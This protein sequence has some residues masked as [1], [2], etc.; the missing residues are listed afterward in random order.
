MIIRTRIILVHAVA[1]AFAASAV[2][3]QSS[4]ATVREYDRIFP[5]YPF[6]DPNPIPVVGRIYPYFRFDG[7][8]SRSVQHSWKVVELENDYIRV[9]ILPEIGGKIW[10]AVDKRTGRSFIYFNQTVKFRDIAMRGP[11]TSGGI[12]ANY[13]IIGHTPNVATPVDYVARTNADGSVSCIIGALD[14]LTRTPWRLE[15]RLGRN[16]AAFSTTSF[17]YNASPVEQPYYSWMNAGIKVSGNLQFIYPGTSRLGHAGEHAPWPLNADGRDV[18]WYEKNNFGGYKS[19]HVFGQATDFVGAYWHDDDFGM[20]RFAPRDEK[21]GKKIWIWGLSRQGMIWEQLLTDTDGQYAEVQSG[22]LFNQSA[23]QSTFTPFKHRGFAPHTAD[24]WTEYWYPVAGTKGFVAASRIG[25][26]NVTALGE[27]MVITLSPVVVLADTLSV[28]EGARRIYAKYVARKP[29]ELF[30]DT[31]LVK[32]ANRDSIRITIGGDRLVYRADPRAGSLARPLDTPA[33]FD[34]RSAYGL[35]LRGKEW[36]RQR[37]YV[38]A[39]AYLDSALARDPYFVPALADR[40]MLAIMAMDYAA[41][42]RFASTALSVDTYDGAANYYYGIANRRLGKLAD[43]K[44]GF[45]VAASSPEFRGA[46]WTELARLESAAGRFAEAAQYAGK[47]LTAEGSNLDAIGVAIVAA[48]HRDERGLRDSLLTRL[49]A[50]DPLSHQARL[51]RL[52]AQRDTALATKLVAG[53]RSELPEQ[54]LLD[55]AAWYIEVGDV[56]VARRV[57]ESAG[58]QP[59]ALYWRAYLMEITGGGGGALLERATALSPRLVFPFRPEIVPALESAAKK[60]QHWKPRY[61]LALA[62]WGCGRMSDAESL[63]NVLGDQPDYAPLFAARASFPGRAPAA[64]RRDLEHAMALD[65]SEW[66]YGK[67]LAEQMLGSGD[68]KGAADVARRAY[69]RLPANYILGLT[70]ARSLVAAGGYREADALLAVLDV[71]PYEGA[72]DGHVLYRQ[73][74]LMLAVEAIGARK[75]D[76][77]AQLI[78]SARQ[79]PERLGAGK[80]YDADNDERL[81]DWLLADVLDRGG[82]RGEAI[83]LWTR[84][85][86][87]RTATGSASD[88][89]PLWSLERLG[90]SAEAKA[91][92]VSW[93]ESRI[94]AGGDGVV[95]SAWTAATAPAKGVGTETLRYGVGVWEPDSLGN[96]RAVVR[97]AAASDAV[98]AHVPWRRRDLKPET[99]NVVVIAAATQQRVLNVARMDINR[100]YGEIVFQAAEPG[101]YYVYYMPYTGT[102]KSNYPKITYRVPDRTAEAAWLDRN[103]LGAAAPS[104]SYRSLPTATM[105]G[106]DAVNDFSR[107]TPM[108]YIAGAAERDVLRVS[109]P[110]AP[111]LAFAEDRSLSIRMTGDIPHVWAERGAFQPFTG[112]AK[113][114]EFY[115]FQIGVW[116]NR[117]AVDSLRYRASAFTRKGGTEVIPASSV[118]AFNLE[119]TD[120]SGQRFARALH[121]D[122]GKVQALWYGVEVP[123]RAVPGDYEGRITLSSRGADGRVVPVVIR[124]GTDAVANHGDDAPA[125]LTRLRWLNSQ[126]AADDSVVAPFTAMRVAGTT[127]SLLGRAL[128]FGPDG[129]PTSI[130]SYFT[131][132]NSAI[133]TTSREILSAPMRLIVRDSAG[134]DLAWSGAAPVVTKRAV[135]AVVW[136]TNKTAAGLRLRSRARLEFDGTAEYTIA[137]RAV[138][139][140]SLADVRFELPIRADAAKYMMGLGQKGGFRPEDFHWTWDVAKKNQDAAWLGDVNAGLQFTLKDEHYVRPLNTNFYL[141][142]PLIAPRSWANEGKGG[143]DIVRQGERVLVSCYSGGRV[144]EAGDSLRFDFRLMITPFKPLDTQGQWSTRFFHAFVPID[145]V[146]RRGANTVNVHH[147]NRVNPW[148]NYPFIETA[149][150]RAYIDSAHAKGLKAKIYYTVREL[151]NHA[152]EMFALR[153]LGD[154]VLSHGPGGGFSWLQEH[155][156]DD[157][158]PAWHVPAIKDA[159]V[160]NSGVSRWHNFYIEGLN[161]LVKN[162]KID[163][164]YLDDVAFDRLTMKRVRKVLDRGNP[165]AL[166]DLHSANQYNPRDGFASSANLYLEHFPFINRL[167]FGEYFDYDSRPDYWLVE[168]SGIPFGLMGEMLEKGGNPWRGMTLG[169]TARLPW[170]GDPAPLWKAWDDFGIQQSRIQGWWSGHDP[171]TTS[172]ANVLATTWIRTGSA[173]VSLGSWRDDDVSVR[174]TIDWKALG[175]DPSRTRIRAPAIASFQDAASWAPAD[176]ITV[177]AK[178]GLLLI[179]EQR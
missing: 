159:A 111:F 71:L 77:A 135:G 59:E 75:L 117:A 34:W 148:I 118:T 24:R 89:L 165:G 176:P 33:E 10:N 67:L 133:G 106:F 6:S 54:V 22:R 4:R 146:Q 27:Q 47:A 29:L 84:L 23:E 17:W 158:I 37:E 178:K 64:A 93:P 94:A 32:G 124:V 172:D 110:S 132:N 63:L 78:A 68:A 131:P 154:E 44:D 121:V 39:R 144:I 55:L 7:F 74:K 11:W 76:A 28:Y 102:F 61:Y 45:E 134:R 26:L 112:A 163:G 82:K 48:R 66:R 139:R 69:A 136:E 167:W 80:P 49:E 138:R 99:V 141:S 79:W 113:R 142:K 143:C 8:A 70:L 73:A 60:T 108:E 86:S 19:Y 95:L 160:V 56:D 103:S 46:A 3:A 107:F 18:S 130:R 36:L 65:P 114:G 90:R 92:L 25:A 157:Y 35:Y 53:V 72:R 104:G 98:L 173:M 20:V 127:I 123:A 100:E 161:W 170:S 105:V 166:L 119:G 101:E 38:P 12:E 50:V 175:L 9:M 174:L 14:L 81:E 152:P 16:D 126:L 155:L 169:M 120:W 164:L 62:Y 149:A 109:N 150:M 116:A 57:L 168:I 145:S 156:G 52:I 125:D 171:V 162:E 42:L 153:S 21:A 58:D 140:V 88:V 1:A 96:H 122:S 13:G 137:L 83:A 128:T 40:A 5:T 41:A 179:L 115:T 91:L 87:N 30:T 97:V 15:M 147:A 31:V 2:A 43:A 85:A 129:M 151:T 51:E 177:P